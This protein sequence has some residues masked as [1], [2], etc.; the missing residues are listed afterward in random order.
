MS[1]RFL[2]LL[3]LLLL[4]ALI[5]SWLWHTRAVAVVELPQAGVESG[6]ASSLSSTADAERGRT[7]ATE[8][9]EGAFEPLSS[10]PSDLLVQ[11]RD[12]NTLAA[13]PGA[14]VFVLEGAEP[15]WPSWDTPSD[16]PLPDLEADL[17]SRGRRVA[18]DEHGDLRLHGP[19]FPLRVCARNGELFGAGGA[20]LWDE[21][22]VLVGMYRSAACTVRVRDP[23]GRPVAGSPIVLGSRSTDQVSRWCCDAAGEC[24]IANLG[25]MLRYFGDP[26]AWWRVAVEGSSSAAASAWVRAE[27][28]TPTTIELVLAPADRLVLEIAASDGS[29]VA[30][31]GTLRAF[32]AAFAGRDHPSSDRHELRSVPIVHGEAALERGAPGTWI[33]CGIQLADGVDFLRSVRMPERGVLAA[34]ITVRVPEGVQILCARPVDEQGQPLAN[35]TLEWSVTARAEADGLDH[36]ALHD[37]LRS[38]ADG[39]L[40]LA[41]PQKL[42]ADNH[43]SRPQGKLCLHRGASE[44]ECP[45][46]LLSKLGSAAVCELGKLALGP[47]RMLVRGRIVDDLGQPIPGVLVRVRGVDLEN[48]RPKLDS[49][50]QQNARLSATSDADGRFQLLGDLPESRGLVEALLPGYS[51]PR[52]APPVLFDPASSPDLLLTLVRAGEIRICV[53]LPVRLARELHWYATCAPSGDG[54]L[55]LGPKDGAGRIERDMRNLRPGTYRV[56]LVDD[57]SDGSVLADAEGVVVRPGERTNDPRLCGIDLSAAAALSNPQSSTGESGASIV[58]EIVDSAGRPIADGRILPGGMTRAG[59]TFWHVGHAI[60]D[61]S[62]RGKEIMLWSPGFRAWVGTCPESST[63]LRLDPAPRLTLRVAIPSTMQRPD[64]R[65]RIWPMPAGGSNMALELARGLAPVELDAQ[66]VASFDCPAECTLEFILQMLALDSTGSVLRE[67]AVAEPVTTI[68]IEL[69]A[70]SEE[71]VLPVAPEEW[72]AV[73]KILAR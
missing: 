23:Q 45:P 43:W 55:A 35:V 33:D 56:Q 53:D 12:G 67:G 10:A 19:R 41:V 17:R 64:C 21:Q 27:S 52:D 18:S 40:V 44:L 73:R 6:E 28:P 37:S 8:R 38:D 49:A 29:P 31:A 48:G 70:S 63:K 7:S 14:E 66:G 50:F 57:E 20:G 15:G 39:L 62:A 61:A 54:R 42:L 65:F 59:D 36:E 46:I 24:R 9:R 32:P 68:D 5:A 22:P 4:A 16:K 60:L 71:R 47:A 13:V 51:M 1:R 26:E 34:A 11:F 69:P 3:V 58:L 30:V 2:A 72:D 25:W